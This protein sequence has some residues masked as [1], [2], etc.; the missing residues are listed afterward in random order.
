MP[1]GT[2][3]IDYI[4]RRL[5]NLKIAKA[6]LSIGM[7]SSL[8]VGCGNNDGNNGLDNN[9]NARPVRY[10]NTTDNNGNNGNNGN[11]ANNQQVRVA[12]KVARRVADLK[13]VDRAYVIVTDDNAY[14]A[15]LLNRNQNNDKLTKQLKSKIAKVVKHT[16]KSVNDVY[17]SE[18]PDF[19]DQI[20]DYVNDIQAGRPISGFFNQFNDTIQRVFPNGSR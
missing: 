8:L 19:F 9:N 15:V 6:L 3:Y 14:V 10:N 12:K 16:D 4:L 20:G 17:I 7:A 2:L 11:M 18:N 1:F 13:E 5:G